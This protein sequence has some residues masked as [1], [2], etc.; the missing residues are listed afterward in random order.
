MTLFCLLCAHG[1]CDWG[2]QSEYMARNKSPLKTGDHEMP[3]FIA[4]FSHCSIH[5][6]AVAIIT[7]VWWL[8]AMELVAHFVIDVCKCVGYTDAGLDWLLHLF[9]KVIWWR[10]LVVLGIGGWLGV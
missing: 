4:M 3:W 10:T 2:L 5:G 1:L 7:G 8:G 9:C 6:L